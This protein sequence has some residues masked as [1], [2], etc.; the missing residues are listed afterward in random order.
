MAATQLENLTY[1]YSRYKGFDI[2]FEIDTEL[3]Q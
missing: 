1:N 2:I 3:F